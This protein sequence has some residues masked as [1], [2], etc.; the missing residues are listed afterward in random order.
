MAYDE[1]RGVVIMFGGTQEVF[2]MSPRYFGDHWEWDGETW[3]ERT[4]NEKSHQHHKLQRL[5]Q[6]N[7]GALVDDL[8]M[9]YDPNRALTTLIILSYQSIKLWEWD[10]STWTHRE[11]DE[12]QAAPNFENAH[13]HIGELVYDNAREVHVFFEE[14]TTSR[15]SKRSAGHLGLGWREL[16]AHSEPVVFDPRLYSRASSTIKDR[17]ISS[18]SEVSWALNIHGSC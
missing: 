4:L 16:T 6:L 5:G 14:K 13:V 1:A 12:E 2:M 15:N 11:F 10:G 3:T 8:A 17:M 9:S 18:T 7:L